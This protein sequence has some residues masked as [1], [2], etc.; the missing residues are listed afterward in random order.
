VGNIV[1][2]RVA[3]VGRE[4]ELDLALATLDAVGNS[5]P[6]IVLVEGE[7]GIGKTA[8]VRQLLARAGDVVLLEASG[9]ESETGLDYGVVSQLV[10]HAPPDSSRE[11]LSQRLSRGSRTNSFAVGGELLEMLGS[12]QERAPVVLVLDDAHWMD[13]ASAGALLFALRRLHVE[14]VLVLIVSRP[15]VL[16]RADLGWSRVLSD[17]ER[18][19]RIRLEGL[20]GNE[21]GLLASALGYQTLTI[22]AA[23]RLHGHTNGNPLYVKGLLTELAPDALASDRDQLPAPHFFAATVLARLTSVS[24]EAQELVMAASVAG[25]HCP[26]SLAG[27]VAGLSD[28]SRALDEA[29]EADLLTVLP[30][31]VPEEVAFP[32]PLARAAVYDDLSPG[33]RRRLHLAFA[34]Q[35]S[36]PASLAHRV[37]ASHGADDDLGLELATTAEADVASG[38]LPRAVQHLLWASRVASTPHR[39]EAGL[40]RAVECLVYAGDLPAARSRRD[41]VVACADSP[42]RAFVIAALTAMSG[43]LPEAEAQLRAV[44]GRPDFA[45]EPSLLGPVTAL[46]SV[47]CGYQGEADDA[48]AW[49]RRALDAPDRPRPVEAAARQALGMGLMRAGRARE[50]IAVLDSVSASRIDP[51]PFEAELLTARGNLKAWWGDLPEAAEDLSAAIRWSKSGTS[52]RNLPNA[53]AALAESE[54]WLGRWDEGLTHVEAAVSLAED[55][56]RL[57]DLPFVHAIA[58]LLHAGRGNWTIAE[59]HVAAAGRVAELVH[60]PI[61]RYYSC[62]AAAGVARIRGDWNRVLETLAPLKRPPAEVGPGHGQPIRWLM[63]AEALLY[64]GRTEEPGL[65]LE[66]LDDALCESPHDIARVDLCRL[67]GVLEQ[68]LDHP[69]EAR[70]PFCLGQELAIVAHSSLASAEL[71]LAYG[72]FLRKAGS[73]RR[74]TEVL[75]S[76]REQFQRMGARPFL[77]RCDAELAACGIRA[78]PQGAD[79]EYG[80]T[81]REQVV[82]ALVASGKS[83]REVAGELYLS[84]K[85]VEY[86]LGNIFTK[87]GIRSRH[88][89]APRL[90]RCE[91]SRHS[92]RE[93][94][95]AGV[96]RP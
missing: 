37:A 93:H 47:V 45:G 57:F 89:L 50:S 6:R 77:D 13:S 25:T 88:Q 72:Q 87:V 39:R 8:F 63:E 29:L 36:G 85:A 49:A 32:H 43:W 22:A 21:I 4:A 9:D 2:S 70:A 78:H 42:R 46:L 56:D 33:R 69:A 66:R 64:T 55:A 14:R 44:I 12:V 71:E 90:S 19:V 38:N 53:Y 34:S 76:C 54:Y 94:P 82:A 10:S 23:E 65:M 20:D 52:H 15:G 48:V 3:F 92:A 31:A 28:P 86:H 18:V 75:Q 26:T 24:A 51:Q 5:Q 35:T 73:R 30:S 83:N 80:L 81:A 79:A 17:P 67:R 7:P 27:A 84:T 11:S 58:S 60:V 41:E 91:N 59:E 40:L 62:T 68:S 96:P 61:N 16:D 1:G 74:A 95:R